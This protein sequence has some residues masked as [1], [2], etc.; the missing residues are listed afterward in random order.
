MHQF[1]NRYVFSTC[2]V[3]SIA[4]YIGASYFTGGGIG[5][6]VEVDGVLQG[7]RRWRALGDAVEVDKV[8]WGQRRRR[9]PGEAAYVDGVLRAKR[10][11][12]RA[13]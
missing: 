12:S 9:A 6:A 3:C 5:E 11:R 1:D 2:N 13:K 7:R 4:M 8:L 10:S